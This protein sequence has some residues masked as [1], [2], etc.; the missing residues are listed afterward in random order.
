MT[1]RN[2][3]AGSSEFHVQPHVTVAVPGRVERVAGKAL[4]I[5]RL[6]KG[7]RKRSFIPRYRVISVRVL[8]HSIYSATP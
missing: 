3:C 6:C 5:A 7:L 4:A 1:S 2:I 8:D